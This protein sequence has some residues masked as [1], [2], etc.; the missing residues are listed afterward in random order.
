MCVTNKHLGAQ[1]KI[2]R[3]LGIYIALMLQEV[4]YLT[5]IRESGKY[6]CH[7][8]LAP[9]DLE[10]KIPSGTYSRQAECDGSAKLKR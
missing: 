9:C 2:H 1:K 5:L 8:E 6:D 10:E 4:P 3:S 7:S